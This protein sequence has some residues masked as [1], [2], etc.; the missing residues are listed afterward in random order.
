MGCH[1]SLRESCQAWH[2]LCENKKRGTRQSLMLQPL[3]RIFLLPV[4]ERHLKTAVGKKPLQ[5]DMPKSLWGDVARIFSRNERVVETQNDRGA[6][7]QRQIDSLYISTPAASTDN[8][9]EEGSNPKTRSKYSREIYFAFRPDNYEQILDDGAR[10]RMKEEKRAK[11]KQKYKKYRKNV[12]KA[13][14]CS[15][16]CLLV[17]L[18]CFTVGYSTPLSAAATVFPDLHSPRSCG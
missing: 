6:K 4:E 17:G 13:L 3:A 16:K 1:F 9:L 18:Q 14:G 5:A 8:L 7:Y 2:T 11:K 15:W 10:Q 12:G